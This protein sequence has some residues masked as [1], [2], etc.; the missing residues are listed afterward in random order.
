MTRRRRSA[1]LTPF[2]AR[3]DLPV[4]LALVVVAGVGLVAGGWAVLLAVPLLLLPNRSSMLPGLAALGVATAT[5]AVWLSP[6]GLPQDHDGTAAAARR[7]GDG[8]RRQPG[9]KI[10]AR[11]CD[12]RAFQ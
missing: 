2:V 9:Q 8:V 10:T 7:R 4:A 1:D 3:G 6:G 12:R 11:A 5:V